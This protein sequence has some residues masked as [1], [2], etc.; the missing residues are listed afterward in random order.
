MLI[1][2]Y[3]KKSISAR[4]AVVSCSPSNLYSLPSSR[5]SLSLDDDDDDEEGEI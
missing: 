2:N 1:L 5:L 3:D 4:I